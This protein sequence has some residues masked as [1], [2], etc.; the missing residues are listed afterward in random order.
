MDPVFR[1]DLVNARHIRTAC[2]GK[3]RR[4]ADEEDIEPAGRSREQHPRRFVAGILEGVQLPAG[5]ER[6]PARSDF[7][8]VR[9]LEKRNRALEDVEGFI[10]IDVKMQRRT[11]AGRSGFMPERKATTGLFAGEENGYFLAERAQGLS[12]PGSTKIADS[13][14]IYFASSYRYST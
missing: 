1:R 3:L 12:P 5:N 6:G 4:A 7:L 2:L 8:P 13:L 14:V 11:A 10:V 9:I